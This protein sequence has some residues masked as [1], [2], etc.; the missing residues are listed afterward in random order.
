MTGERF[1]Y[2]PHDKPAS[3]PLPRLPAG[4]SKL[5]SKGTGATYFLHTDG[6]S[7]FE[8][9]SEPAEDVDITELL[10]SNLP[11]KTGP[12]A[13]TGVAES[14]VAPLVEEALAVA[15]R[16]FPVGAAEE[17]ED[18]STQAQSSSDGENNEPPAPETTTLPSFQLPEGWTMGKADVGLSTDCLLVFIN[19]GAR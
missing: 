2:L 19:T 11:K 7:Q 18:F 12:S 6:A 13:I 3:A 4:W 5:V 8:M 9:P 17:A 16:D 1:Y 15:R 14:I 10:E